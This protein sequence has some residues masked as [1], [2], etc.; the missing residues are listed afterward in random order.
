[1]NIGHLEGVPQPYLGDLSTMDINHLQ[2]GMIL[3]VPKASPMDRCP[4]SSPVIVGR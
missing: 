2:T 3:Q 4:P 1:M